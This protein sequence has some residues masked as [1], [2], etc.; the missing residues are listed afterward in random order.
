[1]HVHVH[2]HANAIMIMIMIRQTINQSSFADSSKK[3]AS[4]G[5]RAGDKQIGLTQSFVGSS[6][7]YSS[8]SAFGKSFKHSSNQ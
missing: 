1:M 4:G 3:V 2:V 8:P 5:S 6:S 7:R